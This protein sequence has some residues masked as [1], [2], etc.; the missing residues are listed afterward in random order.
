MNILID[1]CRNTVK[2]NKEI[3]TQRNEE[4]D[5]EIKG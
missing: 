3:N 2:T 1:Y 4:T 5:K